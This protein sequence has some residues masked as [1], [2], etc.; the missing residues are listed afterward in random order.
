VSD[1]NTD[2]PQYRKLPNNK[3]FYR[4]NSDRDFDEV[5]VLGSKVLCY[6]HDAKQY[7]EILRIMSM[8]D[9]EEPFVLSTRS[10]FDSE[11]KTSR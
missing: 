2:F 6:H 7:P 11:E 1:K 8:M 4:I 3:A 9:Y 10:E 5:Q